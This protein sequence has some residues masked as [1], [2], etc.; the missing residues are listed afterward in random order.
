MPICFGT[1]G[2]TASVDGCYWLLSSSFD[3]ETKK[4]AMCGLG[5]LPI[6]TSLPENYHKSLC[7]KTPIINF[8]IIDLSSI[9]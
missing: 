2:K 7:G 5:L 4:P 3:A 8:A 9:G 6:G 1:N